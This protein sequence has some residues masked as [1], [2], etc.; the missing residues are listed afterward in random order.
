MSDKMNRD[1]KVELFRQSVATKENRQEFAESWAAM[2]NEVLPVET[3]VRTI[4]QV[5]AVPAGAVPVYTNDVQPIEAWYLPKFG[6]AP[7]NIVEIDEVTVPTFELTSNVEYKIRDAKHGRINIAERSMM[8]LQEAMVTFEET[9]GWAVISAAA[10]TARTI[11]CSG[12][13]AL[14]AAA[15]S[16][17]LAKIVVDAAFEKMETNRDYQVT[18]IYVGVD[19]MYDIRAWTQTVIDP[20]TQREL[21]VN[22]GIPSIY[23][24][25][26][27]LVHF[28]TTGTAYFLDCRPTAHCLGYMPIR[29][30]LQTWDNPAAIEHF[31]V[32]VVAYEEVG[33]T[34]MD[35]KNI[36]KV[37]FA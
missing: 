23:G 15:A 3:T 25:Q 7:Q 16:A 35:N 18:D 2:I 34:V 19:A 29:D 1:D 10:T 20:V 4:Y 9:A 30:E 37:V 12:V 11:T 31:R 21:F 27:H 28:L 8:R 33:F 24:A 32:G 6:Q 17:G 13:A 22:A 36:V 5:E 14:S 26:I